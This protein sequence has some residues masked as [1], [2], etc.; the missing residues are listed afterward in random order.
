M[1]P[2]PPSAESS[3][4]RGRKWPQL[5]SIQ[6]RSALKAGSCSSIL[7]TVMPGE[8][9]EA[10]HMDTATAT[11]GKRGHESH[12]EEVR[13][14]AQRRSNRSRWNGSDDRQGSRLLRRLQ[15]AGIHEPLRRPGA[16]E[17]AF[18]G[19]RQLGRVPDLWTL[20]R[21][22]FRLRT[23]QLFRPRL[24]T[25]KRQFRTRKRPVVKRKK[26]SS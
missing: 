19:C 16:G 17:C 11:E 2:G 23:G 12:T 6:G 5:W 8:D 10:D 1:F 21:P 18:S 22:A 4:R 14:Y 15:H 7:P 13:D 3:G 26:L 9:A 24:R 25:G 20:S